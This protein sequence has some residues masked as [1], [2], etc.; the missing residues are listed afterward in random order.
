MKTTDPPILVEQTFN[1][2]TENV[3]KA[4]TTVTQMRQ[5]YFNTIKSFEPRVG[6]E[7]HFI[8]AVNERVFLHDWKVTEVIPMKKISYEWRFEG[9]HGC[10]LSNFELFDFGTQ[11]RMKLR[12][13]VLENFQSHIA[14]FE[15]KSAEEGWRFL[16]QKSLKKY[17]N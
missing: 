4:I 1:T 11:T 5:W 10:A 9:Y 14:E 7:T 6:F 12:Y 3:W 16:I 8:V 17:L 13:S 2:S 15:R